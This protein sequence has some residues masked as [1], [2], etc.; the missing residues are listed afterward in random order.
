M[1]PDQ[2]S[3]AIPFGYVVAETRPDWTGMAAVGMAVVGLLVCVRIT[4]NLLER[5]SQRRE[6]E[7]LSRLRKATRFDR[8]NRDGR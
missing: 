8:E 4:L 1:N 5:R 3:P 2:I 6:M 7:R